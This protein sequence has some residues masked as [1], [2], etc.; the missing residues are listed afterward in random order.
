MAEILTQHVFSY[1]I[2]NKLVCIYEFSK[3][4]KKRA[5]NEFFFKNGLALPTF[6]FSLQNFQDVL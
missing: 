5:K 1:K 2:R 3:L 4:D 6:N